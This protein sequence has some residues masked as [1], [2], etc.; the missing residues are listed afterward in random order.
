MMWTR[1][2]AIRLFGSTLWKSMEL[3]WQCQ[4]ILISKWNWLAS[5]PAHKDVK[6]TRAWESLILI[7]RRGWIAKTS[8]CKEQI[9]SWYQWEESVCRF[10]PEWRSHQTTAIQWWRKEQLLSMDERGGHNNNDLGRRS[11]WWGWR[12]EETERCHQR[13]WSWSSV[14]LGDWWESW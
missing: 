5:F 6:L 13:I 3:W 9:S 8:S 4:C 14:H 10:Q 7:Q 11:P 2:E 1:G 12:K